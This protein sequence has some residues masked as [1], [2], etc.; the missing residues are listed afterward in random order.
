MSCF[1]SIIIPAY[2]CEDTIE[3]C[4]TSIMS[5]LKDDIEVIVVD[6]GSSD[7]TRDKCDNYALKDNRVRVLHKCNGGVSSARNV[8]IDNASGKWIT[9]VDSDDA[10]A[11]NSLSYFRDAVSKNKERS[12]DIIVENMMFIW[13]QRR[14]ILYTDEMGSLGAII[15]QGH[16]G[17][18]ANKVFL[19]Q[20]IDSHCIR[21]DETLHFYEDWEFVAKYCCYVNN[22][23]YIHEVCYIQYMPDDYH[24]KYHQYHSFGNDLSL[25]SKVKQVNGQCA[26]QLV[27][28]LTMSLL[29]YLRLPP[30]LH[31]TQ[32]CKQKSERVKLII[33]FKTVV[34]RD[35]KYAKGRKKFLIRALSQTD[36]CAVWIIIFRL[37]SYL[38]M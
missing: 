10:L 3:R 38:H 14:D 31:T 30:P 2:N 33:D 1:L 19:R 5:Q 4:L 6:D 22:F 11:E 20:I 29:R 18:S 28:G 21:F 15:E 17:S 37:Y 7:S 16:W 27:D 8:G 24:M 35:V 32:N 13:R 9:F 34:G 25:F 23:T 36:S 26:A 12:T